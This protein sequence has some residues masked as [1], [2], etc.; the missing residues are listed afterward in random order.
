MKKY[1][2]KKIK[3]QTLAHL[4]LAI[5]CWPKVKLNFFLSVKVFMSSVPFFFQKIISMMV[6]KDDL[7]LIMMIVVVV[8]V[9]WLVDL[10]VVAVVVAVAI[11][12]ANLIV[13]AVVAF[14]VAVLSFRR[15]KL[16]E[17]LIIFLD[18]FQNGQ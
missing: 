6:E 9:G 18:L 14:V 4:L 10:T 13:D 8:L 5:F 12:V 3:L 1:V 15:K 11:V 16:A 2:V 17:L 7:K